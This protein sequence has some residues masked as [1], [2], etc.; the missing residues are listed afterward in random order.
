MSRTVS[1]TNRDTFAESIE[2][3]VIRNAEIG[4]ADRLACLMTELGYP[5]AVEAMTDR[6]AM[7][8][9]DTNYVTFV[10]DE[11]DGVVGVAGAAVGWYY[12]KDGVYAR[13]LVLAVSS[14]ARGQGTGSRLVEA[15]ERWAVS[16]GA[17]DVVVNSASHR[18]TAHGF[19]ERR[20]YERTGFRFV[21]QLA[22]IE[23]QPS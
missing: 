7:I 14:G 21:K 4:D 9:G 15:V 6:L 17:R 1:S 16:K 18:T 8:L 3:V 10:A 19:Y 22:D 11:G 23:R 12:E 2:S 5:T 13:L 20:R